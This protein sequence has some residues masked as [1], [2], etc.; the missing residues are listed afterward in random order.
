MIKIVRQMKIIPT[1]EHYV[2]S[3]YELASHVVNNIDIFGTF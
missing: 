2:Y 3:I 1:S